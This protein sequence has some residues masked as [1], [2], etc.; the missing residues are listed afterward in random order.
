MCRCGVGQRPPV[1]D[2]SE[3]LASVREEVGATLAR[4]RSTVRRAKK[5]AGEIAEADFGQLS[6]LQELGRSRPRMV[7]SFI[8]T[9]G[10]S[11]LGCIIP[12]SNRTFLDRVAHTEFDDHHLGPRVEEWMAAF[13]EPMLGQSSGS[14]LPPRSPVRHRGRVLPQTHGAPVQP[15]NARRARISS[16]EQL[17]KNAPLECDFFRYPKSKGLLPPK[18]GQRQV[19]FANPCLS[20]RH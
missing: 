9:L 10:Y 17:E 11:R 16:M 19:A 6:L 5:L 8:L 15:Q 13:D 18:P 7:H 3:R 1:A 4:P 12:V 14:L 2:Q 20:A